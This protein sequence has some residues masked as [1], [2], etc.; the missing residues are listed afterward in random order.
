MLA[1]DAFK[2]AHVSRDTDYDDGD[3]IPQSL[4]PSNLTGRIASVVRSAGNTN[5]SPDGEGVHATVPTIASSQYKLRN[6]TDEQARLFPGLQKEIEERRNAS[7]APVKNQKGKNIRR[8][9]ARSS[10]H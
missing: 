5:R 6:K 10:R 7:Q 9:F 2:R 3:G 1:I 4:N 8:K